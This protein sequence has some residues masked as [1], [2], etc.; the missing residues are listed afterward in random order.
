[1]YK[2]TEITLRTRKITYNSESSILDDFMN[3]TTDSYTDTDSQY[4]NTN[5]Q[6]DKRVQTRAQSGNKTR[7]YN[8][9]KNITINH[10]FR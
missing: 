9:N 2:H 10:N 5:N 3:L 7:N 6:S 4:K 1:M 8:C